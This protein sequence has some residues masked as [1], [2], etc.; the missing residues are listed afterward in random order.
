M[1]CVRKY[2]KIFMELIK[3]Q[4][5]KNLEYSR[6]DYEPKLACWNHF[7]ETLLQFFM[8]GNLRVLKQ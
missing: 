5:K 1:N 2:N 4:F 8:Y 3:L 7:D 6:N